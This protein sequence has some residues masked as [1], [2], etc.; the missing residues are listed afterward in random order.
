MT[1]NI[2]MLTY[3]RPRLVHQALDSLYKNTPIGSYQLTTFDDDAK[4]GTGPARNK[5]IEMVSHRE[6]YL[7]LSDCD[8]YFK[9]RWLEALI[10][11]YKCA[12]KEHGVL[13][14]GG[15]V[16][17]YNQPVTRWPFFCEAVGGVDI[18]ELYALS[19]QSWL[20]TWDV[21]DKYGKF[22]D[23]PPGKVRQ[24]EDW[25]YSQRIRNDGF[26]VASILPPLIWNTGITDSFG[27]PLP[28][29][30]LI[31]RPKGVIVE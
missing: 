21:W 10:E 13:A 1:T 16:H 14:I 18:C 24:S 8:V 15:Y 22:C 26:K 6:D 30:E 9:A 31:E 19:F 12:K 27:V 11:C 25:N 2:T 17:P 3:G 29:A 4:M 23:T 28:G 5:V 20:M 7:Y